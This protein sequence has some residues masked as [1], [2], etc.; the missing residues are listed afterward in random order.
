M[1]FP[2]DKNRNLLPKD[3]ILYYNKALII[4]EK[5]IAFI[6]KLL[7]EVNF[8]NDESI[9]FGK[10]YVMNRLT[11][12]VGNNSFLYG[13]SQIKRKAEPWTRTLLK[14]RSL[15][16]K[17]TG[18]KY[19]SCLLNYYPTGEDGM[20]WHADNEKE[21]GKN[22]VIASLSLGA[23]R[24]FSFKHNDTKEKVDIQ[25]GNGSLLVMSGV[26]QHHWKHALPKTKKVKIPRMNLTFRNII[27][28]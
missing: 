18:Q 7:K 15:V 10:H 4:P 2:I 26:I 21:L 27:D 23:E 20:G 22:P 24:K 14:L 11:G 5:A 17:S 16:E 25:L 19:N 12:W 28:K 6:P 8:K 3:G 13:Y 9:I 1:L